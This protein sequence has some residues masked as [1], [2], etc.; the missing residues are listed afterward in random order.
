MTEIERALLEALQ[1]LQSEH[2]QRLNEFASSLQSMRIEHA[3]GSQLL[4]Q[5]YEQSQA[6]N[7]ALLQQVLSL[8]EQVDGLAQ[9]VQSLNSALRQ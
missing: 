6:E 2:A 8:S 5:Q 4:Q 1:D 3:K 9:R 7:R